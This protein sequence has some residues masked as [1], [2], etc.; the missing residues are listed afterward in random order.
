MTKTVRIEN[1]DSS[2]FRVQVVVQRRA[3]DGTWISVGAPTELN[4]PADMN[5]FG[6]HD[7]QR[8]IVSELGPR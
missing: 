8:L 4:L 6:I 5:A 3:E 7:N 2:A 1:A